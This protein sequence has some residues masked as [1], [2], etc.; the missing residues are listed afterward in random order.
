MKTYQDELQQNSEMQSSFVGLFWF[1]PDYKKIVEVCG[2]RE[3]HPSDLTKKDR[4]DPVGLHAE[5]DMPRDLPR[6][7]VCYDGDMF[8]IWIGEDCDIDPV[9][10]VKEAFGLIGFSDSMFK[11]KRHYHWNTKE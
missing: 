3:I 7:R 9:K 8:K 1:S 4:I 10:M 2:K 6:G 5:H 11:V